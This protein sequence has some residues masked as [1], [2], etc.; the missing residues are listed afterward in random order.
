MLF[1]ILRPSSLLVLMAQPD[2]RHVNWTS[3]VLECYDRHRAC[4]NEDPKILDI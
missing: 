3:S 1:P 4:S 2:E